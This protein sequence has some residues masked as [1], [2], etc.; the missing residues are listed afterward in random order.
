MFEIKELSYQYQQKTILEIEN[1]QANQGEK[2]LLLGKSGSGK[3]TLLN[4]LAGFLKNQKG[5]ILIQNQDIHQLTPTQQDQFRA[6]NIGF[7]FQKPHLISSLNVLQNMLLAQYCADIPQNPQKCTE[8][9]ESL[10]LEIHT[11]KFPHQLSQGQAQRLAVARAVLNNP[12]LI[13]ADEPTASVDDD[14]AQN[15][16]QLLQSQAQ[17]CNA[18]LVVATHDQRVKSQFE[19]KFEL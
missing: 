8:I 10:E 17:R 13:L 14:N 15:I 4:L 16:I 11:H 5:K 2:W 7:I 19:Q 1:W 12:I 18:T 9:L 6:K 3:S